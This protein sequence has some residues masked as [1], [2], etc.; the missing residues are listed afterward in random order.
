MN[1][2][3][4][5]DPISRASALASETTMRYNPCIEKESAHVT[6]SYCSPSAGYRYR[7]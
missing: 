3:L 4:L 2:F 7:F 5:Y 6:R 1:K